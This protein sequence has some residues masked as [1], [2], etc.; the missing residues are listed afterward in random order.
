MNINVLAGI[1]CPK[2]G[3]VDNFKIYTSATFTVHDYGTD[4]FEN[5]E[6]N[7]SELLGLFQ[8]VRD[9]LDYYTYQQ[10]QPGLS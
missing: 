10:K 9:H 6:F 2:C 5:V 8:V 4:H 1:S 3:S 7:Y